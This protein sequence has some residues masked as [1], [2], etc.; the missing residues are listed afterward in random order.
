MKKL[1]AWPCSADNN[2]YSRDG[3]GSLKNA[4]SSK[5]HRLKKFRPSKKP[6]DYDAYNR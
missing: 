3:F 4:T 2:N 5:N 1:I 6:Y